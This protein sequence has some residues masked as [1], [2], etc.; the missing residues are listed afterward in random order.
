MAQVHLTE[1]IPLSHLLQEQSRNLP[2]GATLL[3]VAAVPD[4]ATVEA[5]ARLKAPG[6]AVA[7]VKV[8]GSREGLRVRGVSTYLVSD[9]TD[10]RELEANTIR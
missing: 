4:E 9:E 8:G 5:L 7:L 10:W 1:S 6:R 2:W 3:V